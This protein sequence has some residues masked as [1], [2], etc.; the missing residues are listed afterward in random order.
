MIE[1]L[2]SVFSGGAAG[3]DRRPAQA[4]H[5]FAC[6]IAA[7]T[8]IEQSKDDMDVY[9]RRLLEAETAL[10]VLSTEIGDSGR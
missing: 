6:R 9:L 4:H 5:L 10:G 2:T 7:F 1:V 8:E 3:A